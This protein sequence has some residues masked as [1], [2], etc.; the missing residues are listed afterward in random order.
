MQSTGMAIPRPMLA[1]VSASP[2]LSLPESRGSAE[3]EGSTV[4]DG[5]GAPNGIPNLEEEVSVSVRNVA[6]CVQDRK[7]MS[8]SEPDL[9]LNR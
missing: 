6:T 8:W 3:V 1:P 4:G 9:R 5:V 7:S 2:W